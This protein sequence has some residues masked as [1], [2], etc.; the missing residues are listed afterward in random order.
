MCGLFSPCSL[1][2]K[3]LTDKPQPLSP[4][5]LWFRAVLR[6]KVRLYAVTGAPWEFLRQYTVTKSGS[7]KF[8]ALAIPNQNIRGY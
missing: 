5:P 4:A 6:F 8:N 7:L 3:T 2:A 1:L